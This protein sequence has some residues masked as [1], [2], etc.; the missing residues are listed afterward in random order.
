MQCMLQAAA[1]APHS[2][3]PCAISAAGV[4]GF[5]Q[6]GC[7]H[8]GMSHS[9]A[10]WATLQLLRHASLLVLQACWLTIGL[11][12]MCAN[13]SCKGLLDGTC[14]GRKGCLRQ[15]LDRCHSRKWWAV[16]VGPAGVNEY[17][18]QAGTRP[19]A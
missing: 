4:R 17:L 5:T 10:D 8:D 13:S 7:S 19:G 2:C 15:L 12:L 6:H 3:G 9:A 18:A 1:M 16:S 14:R 11:R